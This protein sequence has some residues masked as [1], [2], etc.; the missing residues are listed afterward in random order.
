MKPILKKFR[1]RVLFVINAGKDDVVSKLLPEPLNH[2]FSLHPLFKTSHFPIGLIVSKNS[3]SLIIANTS[4][5][6]DIWQNKSIV[7]KQM[8]ALNEWNAKRIALGG[9]LPSAISKFD[10]SS[11][12]D[13]RVSL[14]THGT[15]Y[16]LSQCIKEA[17]RLHSDLQL[18]KRP[19]SIIGSG[20]IG[21]ALAKHLENANYAVSLFDIVDKQIFPSSK[22]VTFLHTKFQEVSKSGLIV[23]LTTTGD[24]GVT[25]IEPHLLPNMVLLSDTYPKVSPKKVDTL[26]R[27]G[28]LYFECH[29]KLEKSYM[30]PTYN[31]M[32]VNLLGGCFIQSYVESFQEQKIPSLEAFS[33]SATNLGIRGH[34]HSPKAS[35]K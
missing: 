5:N 23:L 33:A 22:R 20:Y 24:E 13:K 14:N 3:I 4:T 21:Q 35:N 7:N 32:P 12:V 25:S 27:K 31:Y 16:M 28:V 26:N 18:N 17:I 8:N 2:I 19:I 34:L 30:L 9:V 1:W 15:V 6:Q 11:M 29:A 10:L